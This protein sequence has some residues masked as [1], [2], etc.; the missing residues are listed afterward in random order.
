VIVGGVGAIIVTGLAC[1]LF[2]T[3]RRTD[4]LSAESL[5]QSNLQN[6]ISEPLD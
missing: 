1:G 3:L 2:P 6:S 4:A 5:L